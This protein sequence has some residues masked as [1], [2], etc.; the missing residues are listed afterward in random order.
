MHIFNIES[1]PPS[2]F[3]CKHCILHLYT[4]IVC[5]LF[6]LYNGGVQYT[7]GSSGV[8]YLIELIV[9]LLHVVA[10]SHQ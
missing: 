1:P 9:R 8:N 2:L 7:A 6:G 4:C 3:I 5:W 10:Y